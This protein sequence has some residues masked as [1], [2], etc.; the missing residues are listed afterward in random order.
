M[1]SYENPLETRYAS[2]EMLYN[3]S[4][5]MKFSTW[6]KLWYSLAKFQKELGVKISEEQ[7]QEIYKNINNIDYVLA[8]NYEKKFKHDVMAHIHTL[9][10]IAPKA[11]SI[12]HLGATSAFVVD[13]TDL[14]Q[15]RKG[16]LIIKKRILQIIK[17]MRNF[18]IK[19][20][21]LATL[22]F[23]HFQPAQLTTV[24]KRASMWLQSLLLDFEELVFRLD[25]LRFRGVKGAVG[26]SAS[27]KELFNG[28]YK[29]MKILDKK[30]SRYFGFNLFFTIT[31]QT[32]DR[33][34]DS[35][36]LSLLS[37]IA[38]TAHK[39]S[40]DL[41][42]LSNLKELEEPF[43]NKQI[44]SSAMPYK[45]NPIRSERISSLAKF[46]ISLSQSTSF[47]AATQWL[48]RSLDDSANKRLAIPQAFLATD[49][50]LLIWENIMS[51]IKVYPKKIEQHIDEEIPF[52]I[53]ESVILESVKNGS[54]RQE[55]HELIRLHSIAS[56][57]QIKELGK[58]NDLINRI[59]N[60][61]RILINKNKILKML[62][63]KNFIGF[64][65]E[66][67]EEFIKNEV[68]E[69]LIK[70]KDS[71]FIEKNDLNV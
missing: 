52:M 38:Q 8:S 48:E 44:G 11:K 69:I 4:P 56:N 58:P 13:N 34:I 25:N 39:F 59:I 63:P 9:G 40:T 36:I 32:Y 23:T 18:C 67:T 41:R 61:D 68:D 12:L 50:I 47:T 5:N 33:K 19:Y 29:K 15:I 65:S 70:N 66:Q 71:I 14:I 20:K 60:D 49:S 2:K 64:A 27:F 45:K 3:F 51:N 30:L 31:G 42:L 6:R 21:K 37:N 57:K 10:D 26:S 17:L 46:V 55:V 35:V 62:N 1:K 16:L 7:I 22:G 54:D 53:T 24:G 43:E 28:D